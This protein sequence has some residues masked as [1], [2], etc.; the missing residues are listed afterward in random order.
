MKRLLAVALAATMLVASGQVI[1]QG[2]GNSKP[3]PLV[4]LAYYDANDVPVGRLLDLGNSTSG[5]PTTLLFLWGTEFLQLPVYDYAAGDT[6]F[7]NWGTVWYTE[8]N[9]TGVAHVDGHPR[10][11]I[12]GL[13]N[14]TTAVIQTQQETV[15]AVSA[16]VNGP[17]PV[18]AFRS[19]F[20]TGI[21]CG[22]TSVVQ[23]EAFPPLEAT[24]NVSAQFVRP[25]KL[26]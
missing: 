1:G 21:G 9:C 4:P 10:F 24:A 3:A 19:R 13:P 15:L 23:Q 8:L 5:D 14:R 18:V 26:K 12:P 16:I 2:K 11:P 6:W 22:N 25:L 7:R 20:D 17:L